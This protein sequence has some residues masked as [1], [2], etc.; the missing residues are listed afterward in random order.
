MSFVTRTVCC[1]YCGREFK[2]EHHLRYHQ[3]NLALPLW[4]RAL[5][6]RIMLAT[7]NA[8]RT[9]GFRVGLRRPDK[10]SRKGD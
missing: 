4:V 8:A 1:R 10:W 2:A 6:N 9:G 7:W 5:R 3:D